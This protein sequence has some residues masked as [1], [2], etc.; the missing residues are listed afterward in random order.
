MEKLVVTAS[1][2]LKLLG[3]SKT[4]IRANHRWPVQC[5]EQFFALL[6]VIILNCSGILAEE[7]CGRRIGHLSTLELMRRSY[8]AFGR[9][10][11]ITATAALIELV[12]RAAQSFQCDPAWYF[13]V[14][15]IRQFFPMAVQQSNQSSKPFSRKFVGYSVLI[16]PSCLHS[17]LSLSLLLNGHQLNKQ[18]ERF[19]ACAGFV[20]IMNSQS[21]AEVVRLVQS[22]SSDDDRSAGGW[23]P[24]K[25]MRFASFVT[26]V[27]ESNEVAPIQ[28]V[29]TRCDSRKSTV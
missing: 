27:A 10:E 29:S 3:T 2:Q 18:I 16:C 11:V 8:A 5:K 6:D 7:Q 13:Q 17:A 25:A 24:V 1:C 19:L 15:D 4:T 9:S 26:I 23:P 20:P 28:K 12:L 14:L 21:P 22:I